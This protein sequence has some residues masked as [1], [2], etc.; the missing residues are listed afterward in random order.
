[1]IIYLIRHAESAPR[2][3]MNHIEGKSVGLSWFGRF[4]ARILAKKLKKL[5]VNKIISSPLGRTKETAE[6][7]QNKLNTPIEFDDRLEEYAPSRL[8]KGKEFKELKK[9]VRQDHD[10]IPEDGESLNQSAERF[11]SSVV[12]IINSGESVPCV[13][14]HALIIQNT[15]INLFSLKDVPVIDEV[16]ITA[17][18]YVDGKFNLVFLNKS[19]SILVTL[20]SRLRKRLLTLGLWD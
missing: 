1:M 7:I 20:L 16:S 8:L 15:L 10:F 9:K 6:I 4:Q 13:V 17:I 14:S 3:G 5:G 18:E 2:D 12:D 19:P 11:V